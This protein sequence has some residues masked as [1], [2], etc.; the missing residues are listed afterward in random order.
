M[1]SC[2]IM[3]DFRRMD[4]LGSRVSKSG[5]EAEGMWSAGPKVRS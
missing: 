3:R 5:S 2:G 4:E 1:S